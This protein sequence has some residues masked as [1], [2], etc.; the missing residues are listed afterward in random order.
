MDPRKHSK[1]RVRLK[2]VTMLYGISLLGWPLGFLITGMALSDNAQFS[3]QV[4]AIPGG[5]FPWW[6]TLAYPGLVVGGLS[7]AWVLHTKGRY[8]AAFWCAMLPM[9]DFVL[10]VSILELLTLTILGHF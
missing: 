8:K 5:L 1:S 4:V 3:R 6:A 7:A 9:I 2:L 10:G